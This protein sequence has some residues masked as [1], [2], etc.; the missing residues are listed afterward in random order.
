MRTFWILF[1]AEWRHFKAAKGL[2]LLTSLVLLVGLYGIY[3]GT[4]EINRQ[5]QHLAELPALARHNVDELKVKFPGEAD[6]GEIGYY[7]TTFA[8]HHPTPWASLSL[9]QRDVNPYYVKLRLLGL[10]GQLYASE[11]VNPTKALSGNF[12]LA[13]VLVYLFPLLI[14]ALC[15][16]LL[17]SEKEQGILTL[18]LAQPVSAAT[19]VGAKL[20]FR[21]ALVL[22]LVLVLSVV[23]MLWAQV[24]PDGR[25]GLWLA[26]ALVYCLFWFGVAFL[27]TSW[28]RNSAFNAVALVGVWLVLVVLVP[29]LLN[30]F[31]SAAR[32]VPQDLELTIKQREEIHG[33]WDKPKTETMN[34]FFALYPQFRDTATIKERF[35]WRWYYAFQHLGDQSVQPLTVAYTN[36]LRQ[37]YDLV[38]RLSWLSPAVAAQTSLNALAGSDLPAHLAF[39][40]SA[41]RYHYALRA[42]YYPYLFHKVAFTHADFAKEPTHT[43]TS[44]SEPATAASGLGKLLISAGVVFGAGLLLFRA[45]PVN[46]R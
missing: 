34:R 11:N 37:R 14:I 21:L 20:A 30:V 44:T 45:R 25:V 10:Q 43:F 22:G 24:P 7:H 27:I 6:A 5:R 12:D 39:L 31:V 41:S 38:N 35:V 8:V 17:S 29:G 16:N 13:F 32:P 33:G 18:L 46:P 36:G 2:V 26:L 15:F 3:Y 42:F 19:L 9:G 40:G 23:A 28:Q 1:A 4:S